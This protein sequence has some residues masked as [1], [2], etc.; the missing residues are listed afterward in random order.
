MDTMKIY[1]TAIAADTKNTA[2]VNFDTVSTFDDSETSTT[3]TTLNTLGST[4]VSA[5]TNDATVLKMTPATAN[6]AAAA[7]TSIAAIRGFVI[8]PT[9]TT[10]SLT[11]QMRLLRFQLLLI[12]YL[13]TTL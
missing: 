12:L 2:Q 13:E 3:A 10:L 5:T 1:L 9:T 8:T 11:Q 6:S 4:A 7:K